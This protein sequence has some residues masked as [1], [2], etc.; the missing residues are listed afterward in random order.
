MQFIKKLV[1]LTGSACRGTLIVERNSHGVW[2]KLSLFDL[3]DGK[4]R[5][6]V[7]SGDEVIVLPVS[8]PNATF[9]LGEINYDEIHAAVLSDRVIMYGSNCAKKLSSEYMLQK[10]GA[11]EK[12][13]LGQAASVTYSGLN[14]TI[15]DYFHKIAPPKYDDFAI[16]EKNYFPA[17]VTLTAEQSPLENEHKGE[18]AP[19]D[20]SMSVSEA[21]DKNEAISVD[22]E[23][24]CM[25]PYQ[26]ERRYLSLMQVAATTVPRTS[27]E[28]AQKTTNKIDKT[29]LAVGEGKPLPKKSSLKNCCTNSAKQGGRQATYLEKSYTRVQKLL[30]ENERFYE[31]EELIP[32]SQF[33]KI[34]YDEKRFYLVGVLGKDYICYGVPGFYSTRPPEPLDGYARWLP[35]RRSHPNDGGFWMMYQDAITGGTLKN[36]F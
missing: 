23:S 33:V 36:D 21:V 34:R 14:Q 8:P 24:F 28:T 26:L 27:V 1:I 25:M 30:R 13:R 31:I 2:C 6:V 32:G 16:A 12:A 3:N 15:D 9:E 35:S 22:K 5:L 17:Y 7:V 19:I 29:M 10:A 4:Y 11:H 18:N 20:D